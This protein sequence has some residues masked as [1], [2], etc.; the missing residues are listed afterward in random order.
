VLASTQRS[1]SYR[2]LLLL[3]DKMPTTTPQL[4]VLSYAEALSSPFTFIPALRQTLLTS[5][6][7]YLADIQQAFPTWEADLNAA[8]DVSRRF[9]E[10]VSL[11]EKEGMAMRESKHFRGWS[12]VGSERTKG[13][14]DLREQIDLG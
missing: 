10:D 12:G 3:P 5:G 8:F 6:F 13:L 2:S 11:E 4:P 9:F 14:V 1:R 7:F